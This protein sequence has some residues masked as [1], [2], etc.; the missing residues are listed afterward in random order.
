ML[1][2][3]LI[4][5]FTALALSIIGIFLVLRNLSMTADG[6][7]HSV[8]LGIVV[9]FL[10]VPD[11]N[12]PVLLFGAMIAGLLTVFMVEILIKSN[13][14]KEDAALGIIFPFL[15]SLGVLMMSLFLRNTH[16]CVDGVLMGEVLVSPLSRTEFLGFNIPKALKMAI[17]ALTI[18]L[19]FITVFFK[20]LKLTAFDAGFA[21]LSGF[22]VTILHYV[23][24]ALVSLNAVI[25]FNSVGSIL[26]ISFMIAPAASAIL[27]TKNLKTTII[28]TMIIAFIN[29]SIGVFIGYK[30]NVN[31]AG[32][33]A[34]VGMISYIIAQ[35]IKPS[36]AIS[37]MMK[38]KEQL[39]YLNNALVMMHINNHMGKSNQNIELGVKTMKNHLKMDDH[40]LKETIK[41][42]KQNGLIVE[43]DAYLLTDK[44]KEY[45]KEIEKKNGI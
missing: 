8:L 27:L 6:I 3:Y 30:L 28:V 13:K 11:F 31:L 24:M 22:S 41:R 14:V 37:K 19:V 29:V 42:L 32:T 17:I 44:G 20:E 25:S 5:L 1:E 33:T 23:S 16:L 2:V 18:N 12:S 35:I 45:Y 38:R 7:S 21:I 39:K 9:A 26:V 10:I 36:G 34:F 40:I 4:M 15:F 43:G